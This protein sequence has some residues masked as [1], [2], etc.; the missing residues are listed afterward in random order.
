MSDIRILV[1]LDR[2]ASAIERLT[3]LLRRRRFPVRRVAIS[4]TDDDAT[5]VVIRIDGDADI[6][7]LR[8][9]LEALEDVRSIE[10]LDDASARVTRELLLAWVRP[11][12]SVRATGAARILAVTDGG[13]LMEMTGS[14]QE[15]ETTLARLR[16]SGVVS[17]ATR[18]EIAAPL[19]APVLEKRSD[20]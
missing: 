11:D 12:A 1:R 15:I 17:S 3:G 13:C 19:P 9:E 8:A 2:R 16:A 7:R 20:G 6:A 4:L 18:S 14:P 5:E 10:T